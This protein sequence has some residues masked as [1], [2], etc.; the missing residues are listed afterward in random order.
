MADEITLININIDARRA[1]K[2]LTKLY[3]KGILLKRKIRMLRQKNQSNNCNSVT[4]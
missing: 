4:L 1:Q 2:Q 3:A